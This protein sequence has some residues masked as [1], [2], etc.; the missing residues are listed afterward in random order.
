[1]SQ[2]MRERWEKPE[3]RALMLEKLNDPLALAVRREFVAKSWENPE[4]R[5][6]R[7]QGAR[8]PRGS[9][10]KGLEANA[11]VHPL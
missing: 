4:V 11:E 10:K 9:R 1:M 3:Y 6:K 8:K 5:E 7:I 2:R